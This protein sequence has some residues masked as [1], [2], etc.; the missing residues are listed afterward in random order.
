MLR[1]HARHLTLF[2]ISAGVF[3]TGANAQDIFTVDV[4]ESGGPLSL[5][6]G[7]SSLPD[8]VSDLA[9]QSG[10][11]DDF[12]GLAFSAMLDYGEIADAIS[13]TFDPTGGSLGGNLF[14]ID[15][16]EGFGGPIVF[17]EADG[18]LGNQLEDFFLQDNPD[19][20]GQFLSAIAEQSLLAIT[21]GNPASATARSADYR[22]ERFGLG[23][24]L[25]LNPG[26]LAS[27][28]PNSGLVT[29]ADPGD[30]DGDLESAPTGNP[31]SG[32]GRS[33]S[34]RFGGKRI[35][36]RI[37][38]SYEDIEVGDFEGFAASLAT[39]TEF[40]IIDRLSLVIGGRFTYQ[41]IEDADSFQSGLHVDVP[42]RMIEPLSPDGGFFWDITPGASLDSVASIDLAAGG[43]LYSFG[44][45]TRVGYQ[46]P[47]F[48]I[49]GAAQYT[50][51]ESITLKFDDYE[52]DPNVSQQIGKVGIR[53]A[54][55]PVADFEIDGGVTYTDFIEDAAVDDY[56]SPMAGVS[57]ASGNGFNIRGGWQ[58]DFADDFTRHTLSLFIHLPF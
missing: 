43:T 16:L 39:S 48:S 37:D 12:D 32:F 29:P 36:G 14:T 9:D 40:V 56:V 50:V 51:H 57:F 17:D 1:I 53:A 35:F 31:F 33:G 2:L 20:I 45:T 25:T 26:M 24:D 44:T 49:T 5:S 13:V 19:A 4:T 3:V 8:L 23:R 38:L 41:A 47:K 46:T 54:F 34:E 18:D 7:G 42:I 6:A 30:V 55:R 21:D 58:G 22:F 27:R 52:F 11:F 10:A 15:N 28:F